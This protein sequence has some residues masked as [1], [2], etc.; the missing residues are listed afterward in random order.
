MKKFW[1]AATVAT[2]ALT[3]A[4]CGKKDEAGAPAGNIAAASTSPA[5]PAVPYSGKDWT[6]VT[7][8]TPEGGFRMGNP[9]AP[10]KLVEYASIT[11]P[12]CRDF[13]KSAAEPLR[14]TY[15]KTGKVSWEFR[16]F[17]MNP[18]DVAAT[19]VA[20]CQGPEPF[21]PLA[22][23]LYASQTQWIGKFNSVDEKTLQS[24]GTLPQEQQFIQ[25]ISLTGLE[26]FFK[27]RGVP[28]ERIK[29]CL[30]DKAGLDEL[31]KI[32]DYATGT[33]KID[34]TPSFFINGQ[35]Q[36]QVYDWPTLESKLRAVVR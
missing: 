1:A 23:Q 14:E 10:V 22:E 2:M 5:S 25:L 36:D 28:A 17:V 9:D 24:M 30:S 35:K 4:G 15:V 12:H 18:L 31:L 7:A 16:N 3:V 32:R 20:R 33:D 27:T 26:D 19:L 13:T 8:K 6:E 21:F 34:G 29:A 11:C